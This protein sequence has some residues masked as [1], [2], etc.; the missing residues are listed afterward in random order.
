MDWRRRAVEVCASS[1]KGFIVLKKILAM[2]FGIGVSLSGTANAQHNLPTMNAVGRFLGIGW[3]RGYHSGQYDGRFQATKDKHPASM[4][5]SRGLLYPF[6]PSYSATTQSVLPAMYGDLMLHQS[7]M[8]TSVPM[9]AAMNGGVPMQSGATLNQAAPT[10]APTAPAEPAPTWLRPFL[11][12]DAAKSDQQI[13]LLPEKSSEEVR[14]L[15]ESPT[16]GSPSDRAKS[17]GAEDD[18]DLLLPSA[19]LTPIQRYYEARQRGE[20]KR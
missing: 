18:D 10:V 20:S 17:K 1:G 2:C 8:E 6:H 12:D 13:E 19:R 3:N 7:P 4:Y 5:S 11:K 9:G 15:E 14:P 16:E